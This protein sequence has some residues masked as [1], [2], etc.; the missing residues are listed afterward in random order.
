MWQQVSDPD[1]KNN[2]PV[3]KEHDRL[4]TIYTAQFVMQMHN[5]KILN[6]KTKVKL[7]EHSIRNGAK[8]CH[9]MANIKI[10]IFAPSFHHFGDIFSDASKSAITFFL[11]S[12]ICIFY[13]LFGE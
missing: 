13:H 9:L 5:K 12:I 7:M 6:F 2:N 10:Y 8:W 1:N 3:Y 11:L 4:H